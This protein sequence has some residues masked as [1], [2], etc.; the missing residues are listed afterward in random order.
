MKNAVRTMVGVALL[1]CLIALPLASCQFAS[2]PVNLNTWLTGHAYTVIVKWTVA[3]LTFAHHSA[4]IPLIFRA[5][6]TIS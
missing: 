3:N 1:L 5:R 4:S 2:Q 6:I